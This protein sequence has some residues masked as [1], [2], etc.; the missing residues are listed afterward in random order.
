M[1]PSVSTP[2]RK[3]RLGGLAPPNTFWQTLSPLAD[4]QHLQSPK[5]PHVVRAA[6]Q[7]ESPRASPFPES[8]FVG[9]GWTPRYPP[10]FGGVGASAFTAPLE[11]EATS[12]RPTLLPSSPLRT[13]QPPH[14]PSES[15]QRSLIG[16]SVKFTG[17]G[18]A[19]EKLVFEHIADSPIRVRGRVAP[20]EFSRNLAGA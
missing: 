5:T 19:M 20:A 2:P 7:L 3:R 16:R 10:T 9:K 4:K 12:P 11:V 8:P 15:P 13:P 18:D 6:P 14:L 1:E 17:T